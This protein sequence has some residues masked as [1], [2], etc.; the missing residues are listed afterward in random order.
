[1]LPL[2]RRLPSCLLLVV[3]PHLAL[4]SPGGVESTWQQAQARRQQPHSPLA[5]ALESQVAT[6]SPAQLAALGTSAGR[7]ALDAALAD[8]GLMRDEVRALGP[9]IL[10]MVSASLL[11]R[12]ARTEPLLAVGPLTLSITQ[13]LSIAGPREGR[14]RREVARRLR[15][16]A[17]GAAGLDDAACTA[18]VPAAVRAADS[19]D[20]AGAVAAVRLAVVTAGGMQ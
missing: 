10:D 15:A 7:A 20:L 9:S 11:L 16:T 17:P 4:A 3:M 5:P 14:D 6:L 19:V 13:V 1:M 8:T 12:G 2:A 18:L